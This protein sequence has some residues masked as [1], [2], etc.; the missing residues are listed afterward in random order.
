M[1]SCQNPPDGTAHGA[2]LGPQAMGVNLH[3]LL[4]G[5]GP[6]WPTNLLRATRGATVNMTVECQIQ[7]GLA[8]ERRPTGASQPRQPLAQRRG[9]GK[10]E[11]SLAP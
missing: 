2:V 1:A 8:G 7:R 5:I 10:A 11:L 3:T 4:E 6:G 9:G